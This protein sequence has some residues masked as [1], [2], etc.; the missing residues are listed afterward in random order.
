M[1]K[2]KKVIVLIIV[3]FLAFL[4]SAVFIVSK[5]GHYTL[6]TNSMTDSDEKPVVEVSYDKDG[7]VELTDYY[8]QDGRLILEFDALSKGEVT[9]SIKRSFFADRELIA[10]YDRKFEV[11]MFNIIIDKTNG[12]VSFEGFMAVIFTIIGAFLLTEII[13]LWMFIDYRK[14]GE[15]CYQMIA[16]GGTAIYFLILLMFLVYKL[17]ND[18]VHSFGHFL[19]HI[20]DTGIMLI[21]ALSPVMLILSVLLSLSNIQLMRHEGRRPVN[22]LGIIFGIVWF[23]GSLLTIGEGL[24]SFLNIWTFPYSSI[25]KN[26]FVYIIG[27]FECMFLS[28]VACSFLATKYIPPLDR[29]FIIILGCGIRDD[30]TLTPLLKGRVDSAVEFERKQSEKTGKHAVFVPSGGQGADEVISE[31]EAMSRYLLSQGIKEE[32][33][34]KEDKSTNTFENMKFSKNVIEQSGVKI[35]DKKIAFATTNYHVFRGYILAAKNG[36]DAK[37]ISAKTRFYFYPNAF[38]REFIGLLVEQKW[39]HIIAMVLILLFFIWLMV[40]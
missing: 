16:C 21:L 11:S 18:S 33:I 12:D 9:V 25:L 34:L 10:D 15:F 5:G 37:G 36:F 8:L 26:S 35:K 14:K 6:Y 27:Y 20:T 3:I 38:L 2:N 17:L 40:I 30:G 28:T 19:F 39:K 24:I 32:Q 4:I 29:D 7:I 31:S 13:M 23:T 1:M 22:S